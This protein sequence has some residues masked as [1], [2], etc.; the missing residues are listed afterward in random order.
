MTQTIRIWTCADYH[1]AFQCGGWASVR[2]GAGEVTGTAG[3]ERYTSLRRMALAGLAAGMRGLPPGGKA[4]IEIET[5]SA[6]LA[7][8]GRFITS[9]GAGD[10]AGGPQ[11]DLDLWAP[12]VAAAKGRRVT[13]TRVTFETYTPI[14]F[15]AAWA[16]L[17]RDKAKATG[18]FTSPIPKVNL[19]KIKGLEVG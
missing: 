6:E 16:E 8:Y 4:D 11:E 19:T 3:G 13:L 9:L 17:S 2:A 1:V 18:P 12:I 15:V 7:G 10:A 5:T 14:A